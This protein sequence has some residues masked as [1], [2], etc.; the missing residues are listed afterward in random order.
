[1]PSTRRTLRSATL[2]ALTILNSNCA[3][4]GEG[5]FCRVAEPILV[6]ADDLACIGDALARR[7]LAHNLAG[8]RLCGW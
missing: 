2:L 1:M 3:T 7:I 5:D 8:R 4:I 6:P